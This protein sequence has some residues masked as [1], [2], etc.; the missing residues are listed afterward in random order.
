MDRNRCRMFFFKKNNAVSNT[1][2]LVARGKRVILVIGGSGVLGRAFFEKKPGGVF[3]VNI[4]RRGELFGEGVF[5]FNHDIRKRPELV[6]QK[7]SKTV[8]MVDV[9]VTMAYDHAFSSIKNLEREQFL[10]EVELD[11]FIPMHISKLCGEIFWSKNSRENNIK[12]RRKAIH[13]GSGAAFGKT[14]RPE[15]ASYSGAKAALTIM[16]EYLHDYLYSGKGVSA[17]V[18]APGSL[19]VPEI[20][21]Q[22]VET[23]W[24]LQDMAVDRF[25]LNKV[26]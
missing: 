3:I 9:L 24:K 6:L 8:G 12:N 25:T 23:L 26:Y 1:N 21:K 14:L 13:L 22:T 11:T 7:V 10:H 17:H 4:S 2:T 16:S 5:N 20:K 18:V 19:D 15:L